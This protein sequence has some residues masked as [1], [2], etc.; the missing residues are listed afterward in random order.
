MRGICPAATA[1]ARPPDRFS[2]HIVRL[3]GGFLRKHSPK[4][5]AHGQTRVLEDFSTGCMRKAA[6]SSGRPVASEACPQKI[7]DRTAD[8]T[9]ASVLTVLSSSSD[10]LRGDRGHGSTPASLMNFPD[11]SPW[12]DNVSDDYDE[13]PS[14]DRETPY[15]E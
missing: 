14:G 10:P 15:D 3:G 7:K 2:N 1:P 13:L 11:L 6:S 12:L 5:A 8:N 9:S 4:A